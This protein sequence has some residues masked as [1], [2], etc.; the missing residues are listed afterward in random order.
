MCQVTSCREPADRDDGLCMRH[1]Q[2]A[3]NVRASSYRVNGKGYGGKGSVALNEIISSG[4]LG[5]PKRLLDD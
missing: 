3:V 1:R 2:M 4:S 5:R